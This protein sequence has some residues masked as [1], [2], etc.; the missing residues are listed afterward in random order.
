MF[1][2]A[3]KVVG[4]LNI[5]RTDL[6]EQVLKVMKEVDDDNCLTTLAFC[7]IKVSLKKGKLF[8]CNK[9]VINKH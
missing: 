8:R 2:L 6:A 5:N 4:Y 7:W 9:E 1:S 3:L